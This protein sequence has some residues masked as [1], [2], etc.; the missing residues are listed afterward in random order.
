VPLTR[1]VLSEEITMRD[2]HLEQLHVEMRDRIDALDAAVSS[3]RR[4]LDLDE[5]GD[6][7]AQFGNGLDSFTMEL[8]GLPPD[9]KREYKKKLKAH[10][11]ALAQLRNDIDWKK[12]EGA[13]SELLQGAG[14]GGH[15]ADYD[16]E[17]GLVAQGK[18]VLD[19]SGSALQRTLQTVAQT[20]VM[21]VDTAVHVQEQTNQIEGMYDDLYLI[22]DTMSRSNAIMKRMFRKV[23]TDK[24]IWVL[25]GAVVLAIIGI[26]VWKEVAGGGVEMI[27]G[28]EKPPPI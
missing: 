25:T 12:T 20:R 23:K 8:K 1:D 10:R 6:L 3:R 22:E 13:R 9:R 4:Q 11:A 19:E 14:G 27:D 24:Y 15:A 5:L 7:L 17:A 28:K 2:R 26:I 21:A 18:R 16:T